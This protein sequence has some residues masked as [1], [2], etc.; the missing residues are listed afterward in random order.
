LEGGAFDLSVAV[1]S[2]DEY[3]KTA[4][5]RVGI[6]RAPE[7]VFQMT[8]DGLVVAFDDFSDGHITSWKWD[9]GDGSSST[10]QSPGHV[11]SEGGSYVVTLTVE[12]E[13]GSDETS[14]LVR[15]LAR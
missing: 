13:A 6:L 10:R 5:A 11:Y 9:F 3:L 12:N 4:S 8:D 7:A 15:V 1:G 14:R 2:Q